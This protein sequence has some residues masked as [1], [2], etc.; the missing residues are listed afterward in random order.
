MNRRMTVGLMAIVV[1]IVTCMNSQAELLFSDAFEEVVFINGP[2]GRVGSFRK[3]G[4]GWHENNNHSAEAAAEDG[5]SVVMEC[6]GP[7]SNFFYR[8]VNTILYSD[9]TVEVKAFQTG[10]INANPT[11]DKARVLVDT[12]SGF[13]TLLEDTGIWDGAGTNETSGLQLTQVSTGEIAMPATAGNGTGLVVRI[14]NE[15][16]NSRRFYVDSLIIRGTLMDS[17]VLFSDVFELAPKVVGTTGRAGYNSG[18]TNA[19]T[20]DEVS[21]GQF[22]YDANTNAVDNHTMKLSGNNSYVNPTATRTISTKGFSN[23][24]LR[25]SAFQDDTNTNPAHWF[26]LQVN[27]GSGF[28]NLFND[29]ATWDGGENVRGAG[30]S[31]KTPLSTPGYFSLGSGAD[32]NSTVQIRL[33]WN[34]AST[35]D[36]FLDS[37]EVRGIKIPPQGTVISIK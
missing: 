27:T 31:Q 9:I 16:N 10:T 12:G 33:A 17:E 29:V 14:E 4:E 20:L 25:M 22:S 37:L 2:L 21:W 19:W 30:S 7:G 23:I 28:V 18:W 26:A 34:I 13:V 3:W 8:T 1:L 15:G 36:Y 35:R 6:F 5:H 11:D 24:S 32:D